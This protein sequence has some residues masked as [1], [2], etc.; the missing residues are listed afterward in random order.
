[1]LEDQ[2]ESDEQQGLQ[3][4]RKA[5][6]EQREAHLEAGRQRALSEQRERSQGQPVQSDAQAGG[7]DALLDAQEEAGSARIAADEAAMKAE[8]RSLYEGTDESFERDWPGIRDQL[9]AERRRTDSARM[10]RRL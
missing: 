10:R 1:M 3:Q 2:R 6:S 7:E 8:A 4:D 5:R 9:S